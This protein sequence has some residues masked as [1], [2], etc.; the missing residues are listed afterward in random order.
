MGLLQWE[1]KWKRMKWRKLLDKL[2][3]QE[4]EQQEEERQR[5]Y[6][7]NRRGGTT[8]RGKGQREA[9]VK[10]CLPPPLKILEKI[11]VWRGCEHNLGDQTL[12]CIRTVSDLQEEVYTYCLLPLKSLHF[13]NLNCFGLAMFTAPTVDKQALSKQTTWLASHIMQGMIPLIFINIPL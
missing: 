7:E 12:C 3:Q 1:E 4:E 6:G 8:Q 10:A 5:L 13:I 2:G 9:R 11:C